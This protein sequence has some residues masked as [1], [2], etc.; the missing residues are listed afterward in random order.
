M[1]I[2]RPIKNKSKPIQFN[3]LL[4]I[5]ST[6][7]WSR[8]NTDLGKS[9]AFAKHLAQVYNEQNQNSR[10]DEFLL[11]QTSNQ[12]FQNLADLSQRNSRMKQKSASGSD[13][14][15]LIMLKKISPKAFPFLWNIYN[16]IIQFN[17]SPNMWKI[18]NVIVIQNSYRPISLLLCICQILE[19]LILQRTVD[20]FEESSWL[21]VWHPGLLQKIKS[22]FPR[23]LQIL[24][25]YLNNRKAYISIKI[26]FIKYKTYNLY[27]EV[28]HTEVF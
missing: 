6:Q 5:V 7:S 21:P 10:C 13:Q 17:Y 14:I 9:E 8:A 27:I 2:W 3:F 4:K 18:A 12:N 11:Y 25:S 23:Y 24:Q 28:F 19:K 15:T 26:Q 1:A 20:D 22:T 16:A